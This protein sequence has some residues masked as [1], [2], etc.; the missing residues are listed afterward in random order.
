ME[1]EKDAVTVAGNQVK[2][3]PKSKMEKDAVT[4]ARKQV[5]S[6]QKI[7][8]TGDKESLDRCGY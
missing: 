3:P 5:K 2:F 4:V 7:L 1:M 8:H 6:P